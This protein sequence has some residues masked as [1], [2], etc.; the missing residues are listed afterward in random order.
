M[1]SP[2]HDMVLAGQASEALAQQKDRQIEAL[3]FH[4]VR[5]PRGKNPAQH[6]VVAKAYSVPAQF[7]LRMWTSLFT[8]RTNICRDYLAKQVAAIVAETH[9]NMLICDR[10]VKCNLVPLDKVRLASQLLPHADVG[11]LL[12][13]LCTM[14][15]FFPPSVARYCLLAI[16]PVRIAADCLG[17]GSSDSKRTILVAQIHETMWNGADMEFKAFPWKKMAKADSGRKRTVQEEDKRVQ[18]LVSR[19]NKK[20]SKLQALGIDYDFGG[21]QASLQWNIPFISRLSLAAELLHIINRV[22][23]AAEHLHNTN[24]VKITAKDLLPYDLIVALIHQSDVFCFPCEQDLVDR[25][26]PKKT[27]FDD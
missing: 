1:L 10:M 22:K 13:K 20:R 14:L 11:H 21:F 7:S 16:L 27:K 8:P 25:S 4:R 5:P 24:R 9:D 23:L 2:D 18:G 12:C 19:E 6:Y 17:V 3:C 15:I 26:K